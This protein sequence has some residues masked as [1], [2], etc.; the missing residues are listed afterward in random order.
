ML[1]SNEIGTLITALGTG[2]G[3]DDFDLSKLRYHK[4]IIMTDADVD[5]AHIRTLL[6]TFFYRQMPELIEAGHLYIAQPP[7]YKVARGR[8]EVY[9]KDDRALYDH[10]L[11]NGLENAV[12][13]GGDRAQRMGPDL[14][15]LVDEARGLTNVLDGL[16]QRYDRRIMEVLALSEGLNPA[17]MSDPAAA[18]A[19][20][21]G[22]VARLNEIAKGEEEAGWSGTLAEEGGYHFQQSVRGVS[23]HHVI[24][25]KVIDS[26]EAR[27]LN[28][29]GRDLAPAFAGIGTLARG[30]NSEPVA[31]PTHLFNAVVS[32]GRKGLSVQRYKG[33]GE[34]N[35]DQLWET[36]LD[37]EA[38]S[39][40]KVRV[41]EADDAEELFSRLMGDVVEH[42]RSFIQDNALDV[43]NLDI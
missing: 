37:T 17:L 22:A 27:R 39:L 30:E 33:L 25:A 43:A 15:A 11:E 26:A 12:F 8:S 31:M 21:D 2:I 6:L 3:R 13:T 5:G 10:L 24:D 42:R 35:P 34:M 29:L 14:R 9:L 40:L 19:A 20:L 18:Q 23:D 32:Q 16:P 28:E 4:I 41:N 7:L 1:A 36:T 38:R